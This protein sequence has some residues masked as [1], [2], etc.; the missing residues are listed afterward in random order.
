MFRHI[1]GDSIF[2]PAVQ[3]YLKTYAGANVET[4]DLRKMF[5]KHSGL[6]LVRYFNEWYVEQLHL[7]IILTPP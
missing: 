7:L 2:W 3:D 4:S 5:E 6:N 1:L